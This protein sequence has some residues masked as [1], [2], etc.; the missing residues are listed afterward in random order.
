MKTLMIKDLSHT[1]QLDGS[2]MRAVRGGYVFPT[3]NYFNF[4]PITV[5]T[6]KHVYA[7][8]S[9]ASLMSVQVST[10]DGS[11]FLNNVTSNVNP[12]IDAKNTINVS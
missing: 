2:A 6:S 8:Q 5:D 12:S 1:E 9:I 10:G 4:S 11:A 3:N 7:D